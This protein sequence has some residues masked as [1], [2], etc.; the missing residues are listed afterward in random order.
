MGHRLRTT[1]WMP[2]MISLTNDSND[3]FDE[4]RSQ[5]TRRL[6]FVLIGFGILGAWYLLL[7]RDLPL[8]A[9]ALL[10]LVVVLGY[11]V[12]TVNTTNS[13]LARYMLVWGTVGQL[14]LAML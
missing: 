8:M 6:S 3:S 5:L 4:L 12:Q 10:C 1:I 9:S 2:K 11:S 13:T 14:L 7:R